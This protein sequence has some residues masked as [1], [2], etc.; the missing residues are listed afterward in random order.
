MLFRV[1]E[2]PVSCILFQEPDLGGHWFAGYH[3]PTG[4]FCANQK[5]LPSF[6]GIQPWARVWLG[7][8]S[9]GWILVPIHQ[10]H[11]HLAI[12]E[13]LLWC[14]AEGAEEWSGAALFLQVCVLR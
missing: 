1:I 3:K 9:L 7:E 2:R 6:W 4:Y 14:G 5:K 10:C 13:S 12:H 8:W 11:T